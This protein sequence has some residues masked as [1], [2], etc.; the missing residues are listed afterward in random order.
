MF[1]KEVD[2]IQRKAMIIFLKSKLWNVWMHIR[3]QR[4][5]HVMPK[6]M[7]WS[8]LFPFAAS[9]DFNYV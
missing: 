9:V 5:T 4:Q 8:A 3:A 1:Y 7:H 6:M 2:D